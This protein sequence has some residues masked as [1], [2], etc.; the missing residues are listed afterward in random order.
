[1]AL[2]VG[3]RR[4]GVIVTKIAL[5]DDYQ[6]VALEMADWDVLSGVEVTAF[7]DHLLDE[8]ELVARLSGF[9]VIMAMRER[10]PFAR[11]LFARLP[12][13][14]LLVTSGMGNAAIDLEAATEHGVTVCGTSGRAFATAE[15]TWGLILACLRLIPAEDRATRE[16]QWQIGLGQELED[17]TLG[18]LGLGRLGSRVAQVGQAFRMR[19]LAWSQNL[20]SERA[21]KVGAELVSRET[22]LRE[23]DVVTIHLVLGDRT[24][25]LLRAGELALMKPS[26]YLIN[27]SR[28][29]IVD[30]G[31]LV[32]A[33]RTGG[34]AG[35]GIDVFDVEPLPL[36]HPLR[37]LPNTVITPHTGYVTEET[38]RIFY[39]EA[40]ENIKE[41]MAGNP[42]RVLNPS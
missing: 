26:A 24:R 7:E 32:E 17:K 16:G 3:A 31:A 38:Y 6:N 2:E 35:A 15:L 25:G 29:P 20:T 18:V 9:D 14:K 41:F 39:G 5:L 13:L 11:A 27:T 12:N 21:G 28:G 10:T 1:M 22:L 36:D 34:I 4:L 37:S 30:E 23:S 33:L 42:V 8:N 40:L 19:V